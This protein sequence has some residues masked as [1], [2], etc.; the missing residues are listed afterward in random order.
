M[1]I[2]IF[3]RVALLALLASITAC[4]FDKVSGVTPKLDP[5]LEKAT[6]DPPAQKPAPTAVTS[7]P[8]EPVTTVNKPHT[9]AD[10]AESK[11]AE[12]T[13]SAIAASKPDASIAVQRSERAQSLPSSPDL[14][15]RD[16]VLSEDV[17]WRGEVHITGWLTVSPQ[18]TV[19]VEPGTVIRFIP[20]NED[21]ASG[22]GLLV[23][24]RI[25]AVGSRER[26]ILFTGSYS[27]PVGGDWQ[28]IVLLATDK[29]NL[30]EQ[31]RV[32]G[33]YVALD[34]LHSQVTLRDFTASSCG[35]AIRLRDSYANV[36]GGAVS[37]CG[38]GVK[39]IDSELEL[40]DI[41]LSSNRQGGIISGGS[42]YLSGST[43]Y[44]NSQ[45]ALVADNCRVRV[46][47]CSFT[48]NGTGIEM[49][50]SEGAVSSNRILSNRDAGIV[51]K[52]SRIRVSANNVSQ[53]SSVGL[54]ITG[55]GSV[56]WGNAIASNNSH[57]L[58]YSGDAD[59]SAM[60]N[61]W[62]EV[63]KERILTRIRTGDSSGR[64]LLMPVLLQRPQSIL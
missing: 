39:S 64:V 58:D 41:N 21:D 57:D 16:V 60:G 13:Q 12:V 45:V 9:E 63:T 19:T 31:C 24:G 5:P 40:R 23:Q 29:K 43:F 30:L 2:S 36:A 20:V 18:V 33:A 42:L 25:V 54:R 37:S 11:K 27:Q 38:V 32:E 44:G 26:Q 46:T 35:T 17:V 55:A 8:L 56:V 34:G 47:G 10:D 14:V 6:V 15:Y 52:N 50:G 7:M 61:W 59:L 28:G 48:V 51:L 53:N 22:A 3:A 1:K 4:S 49:A 62:G